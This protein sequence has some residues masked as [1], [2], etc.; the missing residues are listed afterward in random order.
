MSPG[1][2]VTKEHKRFVEFCDACHQYRY[3]GLCYGQA[4][5]GKTLSARQ[6]ARWD[7]VEPSLT[8]LGLQQTLAAE[9]AQ[10]HTLFYTPSVMST[11]RTLLTDIRALGRRLSLIVAGGKEPKTEAVTF[12]T[13]WQTADC[14]E[15]IIID[16]ADWLKA[17]G[18]EQVRAI[19]DQRQVGLIFIGMPGL[20]KRLARYPQLYSRVGFVHHF[21][22][23]SIVEIESVLRHK[24]SQAIIG[25]AETEWID[26]AA[27]SA[28]IRITGG[29]F[30]LLERLLSQIA[31]ILTINELNQ[32]TQEVV[33]VARE[34]LVI[35]VT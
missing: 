13:L 4:G 5:V 6:Y 10:C 32:V 11:P 24:W 30:R 29:N 33:E 27:I 19:Y 1:F 3:I 7:M 23:L 25:L 8:Y 9:I 2:V 31:R 16:E 28:I 17:A 12:Q 21:R 35:G 15:L 22:S 18:L 20:E 14:V 26:T 34:S